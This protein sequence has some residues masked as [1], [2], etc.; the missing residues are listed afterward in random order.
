MWFISWDDLPWLNMEENGTKP[1]NNRLNKGYTFDN[2]AK[3]ISGIQA[4]EPW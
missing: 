1:K 3:P 2:D 4:P